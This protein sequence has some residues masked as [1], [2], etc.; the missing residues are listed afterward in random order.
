MQSRS[1]DTHNDLCPMKL[2]LPFQRTKNESCA[3]HRTI[4]AFRLL[5]ADKMITRRTASGS[6]ES[7][8]YIGRFIIRRR[9]KHIHNQS[10]YIKWLTILILNKVCDTLTW[11]LAI[12]YMQCHCLIGRRLNHLY[13]NHISTNK[14]NQLIGIKPMRV[15]C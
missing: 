12:R 7:D 1:S 2:E 3:T 10:H 15:V 14:N 11:L 9:K 8:N 5:C 13:S 4:T 6:D